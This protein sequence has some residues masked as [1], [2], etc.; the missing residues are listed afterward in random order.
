MTT[1]IH[2]QVTL[3][4]IQCPHCAGSFGISE[5]Y[6]NEAKRVGGFKQCWT[7][8][9]CKTERGFGKGQTAL[10]I[11]ALQ[12]KLKAAEENAQFYRDRRDYMEKE[13]DHFRRS[14]DGIKGVLA[15]VKKRVAHGVCP[16]C[17]RSFTDLRR[18]MESKHPEFAHE[19]DD[20]PNDSSADNG[21]GK[22]PGAATAPFEPLSAALCSPLDSPQASE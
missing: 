13:A 3:T 12:T 8:P 22:T 1:T 15:K 20:C 2:T 21:E 14:R 11:E 7:C 9:Y 5:G 4:I 17:N 10:E 16:C 18:H 6:Y 19:S